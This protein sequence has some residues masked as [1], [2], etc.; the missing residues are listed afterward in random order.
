VDPVAVTAG[1]IVRFSGAAM[2]AGR[3]RPGGGD[4]D[5]DGGDREGGDVVP[6]AVEGIRK[7][8]TWSRWRRRN[9]TAWFPGMDSAAS[10]GA[11]EIL[12]A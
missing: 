6:M 5:G 7:A 10:K 11:W 2:M 12:V 8:A 3:R 1:T 9:M 4:S